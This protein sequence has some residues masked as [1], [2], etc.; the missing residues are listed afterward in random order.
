M[1]SVKRQGNSEDQSSSDHREVPSAAAQMQP[2]AQDTSK[3]FN[4]ITLERRE[5]PRPEKQGTT[6]RTGAHELV[7][8]RLRVLNKK[9]ASL[10]L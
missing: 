8:K 9:I 10:F 2:E 1:L 6:Q 4:T 7:S 5:L 3:P